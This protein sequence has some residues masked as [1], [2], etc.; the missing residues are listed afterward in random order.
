M[1]KKVEYGYFLCFGNNPA[2]FDRESF[3]KASLNHD[4]ITKWAYIHQDKDVYNEHD[5]KIRELDLSRIWAEGFPGKEKYASAKEFRD[6]RLKM[7]P[8]IGDKK[9]SRWIVLVITEQKLDKQIVASWFGVHFSLIQP[10]VDRVAI[11]EKLKRLTQEDDFSQG[12]GK[13]IYDDSEVISNFD[14][15]K[16]IK[17]AKA[18][19]RREKLSDLIEFFRPAPFPKKEK[20]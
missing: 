5:L 1:S 19:P 20:K 4:E 18:D 7:P 15:R 6:E 10:A 8:Y 13:H 2:D 12:L 3:I 16:Y 14:F 11:A 9:E 17:E